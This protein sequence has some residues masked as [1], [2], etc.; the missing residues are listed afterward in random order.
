MKNILY[1]IGSLLW[2]GT[3]MASDDFELFQSVRQNQP[4][5]TS[6]SFQGKPQLTSL[7]PLKYFPNLKA[8]RI[9]NCR[10][11]KHLIPIIG[12]LTG[13]QKLYLEGNENYVYGMKQDISHLCRLHNLKT[14]SIIGE[15]SQ[16]Q[17]I[18]PIVNLPIERLNL[19]SQY[20]IED[21]ELLQ[22][23]TKLQRLNL[24]QVFYD[25]ER[26][27]PSLFFLQSMKELTHLNL[28]ACFMIEDLS[29]VW[30]CQEL[31]SLILNGM[32]DRECKWSLNGIE[33]LINIEELSLGDI[34]LCRELSY[35]KRFKRLKK[36]Q[37]N[38]DLRKELEIIK[39]FT[40]SNVIVGDEVEFS[41]W[42]F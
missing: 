32:D 19:H 25:D 28:A 3:C 35:L 42:N 2:I 23:M 31:K 10:N 40:G 17:L 22:H 38:C 36:L 20:S 21:L 33:N 16:L 5:V 13:L 30:N 26:I 4:Q 18:K 41:D 34:Y 9:Q 39:S 11:V 15:S 29:P 7:A 37:V 24:S 27:Y 14:L 8:L 12:T 6:L 1:A